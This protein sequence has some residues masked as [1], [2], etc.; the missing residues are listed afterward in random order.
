VTFPRPSA[1][2]GQIARLER[3]VALAGARNRRL[4]E[5]AGDF[6]GHAA[7]AGKR[8]RLRAHFECRLALDLAALE[9]RGRRIGDLERAA[10]LFR[11]AEREE[12]PRAPLAGHAALVDRALSLERMVLLARMRLRLCHDRRRLAE[13]RAALGAIDGPEPARGAAAPLRDRV[14][15][16]RARIAAERARIA[17][18]R[19]PDARE[20]FAAR[21]IQS[22]FRGFRARAAPGA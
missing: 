6:A 12:P 1:V 10:A 3:A 2:G 5:L 17:D 15:L 16:C 8:E 14:R 9:R 18:E 11:P 13:L 22:A 19:R 21:A 4:R 20:H 7:D